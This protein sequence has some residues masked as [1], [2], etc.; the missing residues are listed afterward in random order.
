MERQVTAKKTLK[1]YYYE[2]SFTYGKDGP[3]ELLKKKQPKFHPSKEEIE[4]KIAQF[5]ARTRKGGV[6]DTFKFKPTKPWYR[7]SMDLIDVPT[8]RA[9]R[10]C[11]TSSW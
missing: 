5:Y 8:S 6:T 4:L 10:G 3:F 11:G 1:T 9:G 7:M 2:K